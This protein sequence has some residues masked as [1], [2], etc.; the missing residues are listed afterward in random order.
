VNT[1]LTT[2][3]ALQFRLGQEGVQV[4]PGHF[5]PDC[6]IVHA[7]ASLALPHAASGA[8]LV[9]DEASQLVAALAAAAA[10]PRVL[11]VCA[12]PGGKTVG[13]A[14]STRDGGLIAAIDLRPRRIRLLKRTVAVSGATSIRVIRADALQPLPFGPAFDLVLVDAPCSGLGTVRRDPEIRWR[15]SVSDLPRLAA[16]Q[17]QLLTRAAEAVRPGGRLVYATCSSEPEENEGVVARFL[18]DHRTFTL[19]DPRAA[20]PELPASVAK[21][22]DTDGRLRTTPWRH[23]LECFFAAMLVK[24][25]NL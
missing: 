21:A 7:G 11:D 22:L 19:V 13:L 9:Q 5:A 6:L 3:N 8:F 18:A 12:A 2:S 15:R 10:G 20:C 14:A 23:G 24:Q 25:G 16:T 1:L 4:E 17:H